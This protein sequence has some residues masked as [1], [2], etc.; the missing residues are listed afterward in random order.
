MPN[1]SYLSGH[2]RRNALAVKWLVEYHFPCLSTLTK[3]S[4]IGDTKQSFTD[5][6]INTIVSSANNLTYLNK[7]DI[8]DMEYADPHKSDL[9]H[10][11]LNVTTDIIILI[12]RA[13]IASFAR[14]K[15][16]LTES[17]P[18]VW[19]SQMKMFNE[20]D[21]SEIRRPRRLDLFSPIINASKSTFASVCYILDLMVFRQAKMQNLAPINEQIIGAKKIHVNFAFA[22]STP[23]IQTYLEFGQAYTFD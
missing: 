22:C 18:V 17:Q 16:T 19:K 4:R 14:H 13:N 6:S 12:D 11:I 15:T 10:E 20:T 8:V 21:S 7:E 5:Q 9:D 1:L 23:D 2:I 3:A